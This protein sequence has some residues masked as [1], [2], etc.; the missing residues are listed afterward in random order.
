MVLAL[1]GALAGIVLWNL[2]LQTLV[3][4]RARQLAKAEV[5][6]V[7]SELRVDER[8]R[9]AV[10]LHDTLSQNLTGIALAVNAGEYELAKRSLKSCR[11][12]LKNCLWDLRN[13]ALEEADLNEAIRRTLA[14]HVGKARL[15]VRFNLARKLLTDK[16]TH[17][18]LRILREL[19]VNAV[20]HGG[21]TEIRIAGCSEDRRIL[22]SLHDNGC[23]FDPLRAPG[24]EEGHFGLQGIRERIENMGGEIRIE[25]GPDKG[26]KVTIW[27]RSKS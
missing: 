4:R 15:T 12:E 16:T 19:A 6:Q 20:R 9:L 10:E 17:A 18:I 11:E 26:T 1:L 27:L 25:S 24:M 5:A 7:G 13:N 8:T 14:P 21:A 22:F 3:L 23:G 2:S